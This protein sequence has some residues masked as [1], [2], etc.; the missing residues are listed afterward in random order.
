MGDEVLGSAVLRAIEGS[1]DYRLLRRLELKSGRTGVGSSEDTVVGVVVDVETTGIGL[2]DA[3]IELALRRFRF[4]RDGIMV[5]IDEPH[6]WLEDPGRELPADIARLTGITEPDLAGRTIDEDAAVRL[7]RSAQFVVAHNASF[8]RPH[9]ERRLPAAAGMPWACSCHDVD[10]RGLG[11]EGGRSLGWLLDQIGFFHGAHRAADDVDATIALLRHE[12]PSGRTVLTEMLERA[13][14][15]SW[16]FRAIGAAFEV[17]DLLRARGYR[18][19]AD[20]EPKAWWRDVPDAEREAEEW[21]LAR[22][23][24]SAE[25]RPRALGPRIDQVTWRERY[26]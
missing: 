12:L 2:D 18:W 9:V 5:A 4:D 7:L 17:K 16:R 11:F 10:W 22:H 24:Y 15:P 6:A 21:W 25:A 23:V 1:D 20:A 8:D 3:I 13:R 14:A 19:D 26:A